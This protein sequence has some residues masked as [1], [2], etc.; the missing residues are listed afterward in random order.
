MKIT[1]YGDL[2]PDITNILKTDFDLN[3]IKSNKM[4]SKNEFINQCKDSEAIFVLLNYTI[5]K[6]I[7]EKLPKLKIISNF[8]VGYNNIDVNYCTKKGIIVLNTPDVLSNATAET[9]IALTFAASKRAKEANKDIIA[10]N[11]SQWGPRYLLGKEI[12]GKTVGVIGAGR[13]GSCYAKKMKALGCNVIYYNRTKKQHL[14][15][16]Q[17]YFTDLISLLERSDIISLHTPL[18][19]YTYNMLGEEEF[20]R[21]KKGV[22]IINTARGDC[23]DEDS[24][25]KYLKNGKIFAAGI[26]VYKNEPIANPELVKLP[27]VFIFPHIGSATEET[28]KKMNQMCVDSIRNCLKGNF[29]NVKNIVN[30]DV[31]Q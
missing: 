27:N 24:M 11:S 18:T 26:D 30:R 29:S 16:E 23:I 14:D 2:F 19:D 7:L 15:E 12:F 22:I 21:M 4:P 5:Y 28:R 13:I 9:A 6:D 31:L 20:E 3:W 8:A 17:I 1:V 25:I 10:S